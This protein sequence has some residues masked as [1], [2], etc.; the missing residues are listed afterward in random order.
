MSKESSDRR[1]LAS[2]LDLSHS[3]NRLHPGMGHLRDQL[4]NL[5]EHDHGLHHHCHG[6]MV[7]LISPQD[8]ELDT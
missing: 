7:R 4:L 2:S 5:L 1:L 6:W 8:Q 3:S